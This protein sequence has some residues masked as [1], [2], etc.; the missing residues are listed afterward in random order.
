[1]AYLDN[2]GVTKLASYLKSKIEGILA[3][4]QDTLVS[5]V[6]IKTLNGNSLLGDGN[7]SISVPPASP[8]TR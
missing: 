1:M 3:R 5:G 8:T 4:K 6:N 2:N 7:V